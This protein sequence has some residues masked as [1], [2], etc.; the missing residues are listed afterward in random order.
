MVLFRR[1]YRNVENQRLS[2]GKVSVL[3]LF[4]PLYFPKPPIIKA[5]VGQKWAYLKCSSVLCADAALRYHVYIFKIT[6]PQC[7]NVILI[8]FFPPPMALQLYASFQV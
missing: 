7:G 4:F 5:C 3:L 6:N 8:S 1:L 2:D